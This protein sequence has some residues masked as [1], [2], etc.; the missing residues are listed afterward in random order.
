MKRE[1]DFKLWRG[2]VKFFAFN[3]LSGIMIE[4]GTAYGYD[5]ASLYECDCMTL[6]M[7]GVA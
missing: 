5:R 4:H 3:P 1:F 7:D 2:L 6:G